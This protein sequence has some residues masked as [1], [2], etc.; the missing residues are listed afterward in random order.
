M[1]GLVCKFARVSMIQVSPEIVC[2]RYLRMYALKWL[3]HTKNIGTDTA[4]A[5]SLYSVS[6]VKYSTRHIVCP[7]TLNACTNVTFLT[8]M[9][10]HMHTT[11]GQGHRHHVPYPAF[12]QP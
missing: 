1:L 2:M 9:Y 3:N 5:Y 7:A 11:L 12:G 4:Y 8:Y 6:L 10:A